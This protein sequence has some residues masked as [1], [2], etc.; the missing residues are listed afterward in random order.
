MTSHRQLPE[1]AAGRGA[2]HEETAERTGYGGGVRGP[3]EEPESPPGRERRRSNED[4][5]EEERMSFRFT[6]FMGVAWAAAAVGALAAMPASA[7]R[8]PDRAVDMTVLFGGTANSTAQVL[9]N[10]MS[11]ALGKPVVPVSRTGGGGA[12]GYSFVKGT[13]PDGYNIVFNSNSINTAYHTGKIPFDYKAFTPIARVSVET[14]ALGVNPKSGWK[15]L[16]EMKA[17]VLKMKRKLKVGIS[18]KGSFTHLVSAALFNAMGIG[19]RV[20]YISYGRGKAPI[21][22]LA[23]RI[24]AAI[25][26][27]GQFVSYQKSGDLR[28]LAVTGADRVSILPDVPTAKEQG[29][30]V[31]ITMWRGLAAPKGT[32]APVI[33]K[34]ESAAKAAAEGKEFRDAGAKLGFTPAYLDAKD[35]GA[36]IA[37][38]DAFYEGLLKKLGLAKR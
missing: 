2:E 26:W 20:I 35:F 17:G 3:R 34:L 27:P 8:F 13:R 5:R 14:P 38:D 36:L 7:A 23:G 37:R 11:K 28:V 29:V 12:V 4:H 30:N 31:D 18:G 32:P 1:D 21:E 6:G 9:A 15:T 24:D 19:D 22:L 33:A 25:Q 10:A 16:A